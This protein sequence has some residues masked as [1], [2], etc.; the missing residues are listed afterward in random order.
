MPKL[1]H[2]LTD[3]VYCDMALNCIKVISSF[4][5]F[6]RKWIL[7]LIYLILMLFLLSDASVNKGWTKTDLLKVWNSR[8]WWHRIRH[9]TYV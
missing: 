1:Y 9:F 4:S 6:N 2:L 5:A 8:L 7:I 3:M